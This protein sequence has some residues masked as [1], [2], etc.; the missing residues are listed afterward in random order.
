MPT[1][2]QLLEAGAHFGHKK[3]RSHP[4]AKDFIFS[5][6]DSVYV[7]NLEQTL[8]KLQKAIEY[9]KSQI[10]IGKTVLFVGTKRQ[11]KEVVK[12]TAENLAMPYIVERWLG[13]TLTNFETIS[14]SLK[15]LTQLEELMK[16]EEF[17]K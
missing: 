4:K 8:E 2:T 9:L 14:K 16:S 1:L 17:G 7:I 11:A 12:K 5:I 13:G 3:E 10:G 6:R 15:Q